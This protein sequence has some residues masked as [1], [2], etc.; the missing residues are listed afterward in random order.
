MRRALL[1]GGT[2]AAMFGAAPLMAAA[3]DD[4]TAAV[5]AGATQIADTAM[6]ANGEVD[7][8][9]LV[10]KEVYDGN[11]D[12]VGEIDSV[13]VDPKGKVTAVVIDVSGW[14]ESEKLVSVPWS[15]LKTDADGKIMSSLT[16][17]SA[18]AATAYTYKDKSMRGQVLTESGE[19]Y[20]A[21]NNAPA[22]TT[23]P[24]TDSTAAATAPAATSATDTTATDNAT[25]D[26][27]QPAADSAAAATAPAAATDTTATDNAVADT[28]ASKTDNAL[29]N[30]D[31]SMN[32]S[33][34]IGLDVQSPEDKKVGDIGEVVLD[35]EGKAQGVVVDVGGFLGIATHPVLLDWKD[36]TIANQDGKATAT[37]SLTKDKLEQLPAYESSS[38]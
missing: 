10:G 32:A 28:A 35:K 12:K 17:D 5:N 9:K 33:K 25:A 31:G 7:A 27:S 8:G 6:N 20:A 38:K 34:L 23:E 37:V 4:S 18:K 29:M 22:G 21:A 30:A 11:G 19:P 16:K 1:L 15:D 14:L 36:V 24:A 2:L 26:T 3:A 13:M